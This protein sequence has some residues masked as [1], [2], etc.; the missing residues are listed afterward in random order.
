MLQVQ[1]L[2]FINRIKNLRATLQMWQRWNSQS[3]AEPAYLRGRLLNDDRPTLVQVQ[4]APAADHQIACLLFQ[5]N[6]ERLLALPAGESPALVVTQVSPWA[7]RG[8]ADLLLRPWLSAERPV[9]PAEE[10]LEAASKDFRRAFRH[11]EK[12]QV[13]THYSQDL[14]VW[15]EWFDQMMIPTAQKRHVERAVFPAFSELERLQGRAVL[16]QVSLGG[17]WIAGGFVI[18]TR[19]TKACRLWRIGM[20]PEAINDSKLY[21]SLNI[22]LD[23][24]A[25]DFAHKN[26]ARVFSLGETLARVDDGL[27]RYKSAWG[28]TLRVNP[29]LDVFDLRFASDTGRQH[30]LD[31]VPLIEARPDG[32]TLHIGGS[33]RFTIEQRLAHLRLPGIDQIVTYTGRTSVGTETVVKQTTAPKLLAVNDR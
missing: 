2:N 29:Y 32:L 11:L 33:D 15:R 26:K 7:R 21:K 28:C 12:Y 25:L 8:D 9:C 31:K 13:S 17:K 16:I 30:I 4:G 19:W 1:A 20:L 3:R 24:L 5:D 22:Y 18:P 6:P 10:A 23:Y 27:F 14:A